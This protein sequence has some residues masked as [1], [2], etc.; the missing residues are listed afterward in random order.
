VTL[1]A[2]VIGATGGI[3]SACCQILEQQKKYRVTAW[4]SKDLDLNFPEEIFSKDF[5]EFDILINCAAHNQGTY[6]G[7][8][9]NDWQN[10][11]SQIMVNYASNLFLFKHYANSRSHGKYV[12]C[13]TDMTTGI[14][15]YKSVYLSTK[16]A[17]QYAID[18]VR[19]EIKH[20]SVLEAQFGAV[21]T[22]LRYRNFEGTLSYDQV[23]ETYDTDPMDPNYV[24]QR[25]IE[26]IDKNLE[27]VMIK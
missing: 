5:G 10:Q 3:G 13:G 27:K 7:F 18:L 2:L 19:Q 25:I 24:A 26:A 4:S 14:T 20:I 8:L 9:K 15:P 1:N 12:W 22:N 6:K 17:S 16:L 21:K 11:L 23:K